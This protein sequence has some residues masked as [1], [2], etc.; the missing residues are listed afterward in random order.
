MGRI[1]S[2][3]GADAAPRLRIE[4]AC[5]QLGTRAFVQRCA[6]LLRGGDE[7][8]EFVVALGG[9]HAAHL[10]R[11]GVPPDQRY[12]LRV[13]AARGLL[14]AG[15]DGDEDGATDA[16]RALLSDESW[17]AREM[18]CKVIARHQLEALLEDAAALTNDS[19]G[20]VRSAARRAVD[21]IVETGS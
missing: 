17:R 3:D 5:A 10:V 21:R 20:R 8:D 19:N 1:P 7:D 18:A 13:W 6:V 2:P 11:Q 12:W 4:A 14:W 16:L 9:S 15:V